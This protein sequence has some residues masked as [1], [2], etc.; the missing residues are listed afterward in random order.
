MWLVVMFAM[1]AL[2]LLYHIWRLHL[3]QIAEVERVRFSRDGGTI[4][5]PRIAVVGAGPGGLS[6]CYFLQ[7][8]GMEPVVFEAVDHIGGVWGRPLYTSLRANVVK[9]EMT[10]PGLEYPESTGR[11]PSRADVLTYL[12]SYVKKFGLDKYIR[13]SCRV[14]RMT[15]CKGKWEVEWKD[16]RSGALVREVFDGLIVATG[17]TCEP[18]NPASSYEGFLENFKGQSIHVADYREPTPYIGKRVLVVGVGSGKKVN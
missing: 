13:L 4:V 2:L 12:Q 15:K 9:E 10:L 3:A 5:G 1:S 18:L 16:G 14:T 11:Y 7:R 17:Q 6:S 8:H